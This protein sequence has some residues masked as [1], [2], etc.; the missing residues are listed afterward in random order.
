[1]GFEL[2]IEQIIALAIFGVT[3]YFILTERIHRAVIGLAGAV[4]MVIVGIFMGFYSFELAL[5]A[6]DFNTIGLLFGMMMLVAL[7][8]E[9]GVFQY[10]GIYTAKKTKGN[11]WLLMAALGLLTAFLSMVLDNVTTIILIAP[12]TI[13]I[14]RLLS[15]SPLPILTAEALLSNVGGAGTLVGDPPN[16]MIGSAAGFSFNAFLLYSLPIVLVALFATLFTLRYVFKKELSMKP[17]GIERLM[18]MNPMEAIDNPRMLKQLLA[19]FVLVVALFFLHGWLHLEPSVIA[20]FGAALALL[21][22]R[23][24]EDP[25][26]VIQK[27][28]L[29]VLLFFGS[30]FVIVGGLEH[31]GLL[32]QVGALITTGAADNLIITAIA[33][34][35]VAAILSAIVDNI[36]FTVAMI[37][38]ITYLHTQGIDTTILW[39]ALILGVGFGGNGTPIGSSAGLIVM[40]KSEETDQPITFKTWMKSGLVATFVSLLVATGGILIYNYFGLY[41]HIE[42]TIVEP[43]DGE[44][45]EKLGH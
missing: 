9:T 15:I 7:L 37:P 27:T 40:S 38:I 26:E 6:I 3:F 11:P 34:L 29:S 43:M 31:T 19:I 20:I 14:T 23:A 10:L 2:G 25:H 21:V 45:S 13:I 44:E 12:I 18:A 8:E 30:L 42:P 22:V 24:K 36:P 35:W 17:Q 41:E 1:M 33:V 28:E 39:W 4:T 5:E 16:I 32:A